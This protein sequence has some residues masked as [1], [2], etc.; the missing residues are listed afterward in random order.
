M[1]Y[2]HPICHR[3]AK[4]TRNASMWWNCALLS[5]VSAMSEELRQFI[6]KLLFIVFANGVTPSSTL[7]GNWRS[8]G[9]PTQHAHARGPAWEVSISFLNPIRESQVVAVPYFKL[10]FVVTRV[11]HVLNS[12]SCVLIAWE[13]NSIHAG[14]CTIFWQQTSSRVPMANGL[15]LERLL[16]E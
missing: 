1:V 6:T 10:V 14:A 16:V 13:R 5:D 8:R 7:L 15:F 3:A 12:D 4:F 2:H 11:V 9:D